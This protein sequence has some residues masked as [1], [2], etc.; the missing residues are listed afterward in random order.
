MA[1]LIVW[2]Q[3]IQMAIITTYKA[4]TQRIDR[5]QNS[6]DIFIYHTTFVIGLQS[7]HCYIYN[8][9]L[10]LLLVY[11]LLNAQCVMKTVFYASIGLSI[12]HCHSALH[13]VYQM[14][15]T[16]NVE[17]ISTAHCDGFNV[18]H[19]TCG[20]IQQFL[21]MHCSHS[22]CSQP[23]AILAPSNI[24]YV[25][26]FGLNHDQVVDCRPSDYV[27]MHYRFLYV[28]NRNQ[29]ND[30]GPKGRHMALYV[31]MTMMLWRTYLFVVA[32]TN[33]ILNLSVIEWISLVSP[34]FCIVLNC[35][36]IAVFVESVDAILQNAW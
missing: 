20:V 1:S 5:S 27:H 21:I 15:S 30:V 29:T 28:Q 10:L 33:N 23:I 14:H 2:L 3:L 22:S 9:L 18:R 11:V 4:E 26:T 35:K 31:H 16:M 34:T 24:A 36:S 12:W 25:G 7:T 19:I 6:V 17:R 32:I 8:F 13:Y